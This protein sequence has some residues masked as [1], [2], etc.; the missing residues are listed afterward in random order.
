MSVLNQ[1]EQ[2]VSIHIENVVATA[3]L[4]HALNLQKIIKKIPNVQYNRKKF[5]GAIIR[6]QSPKVV[7]LFFTTGKLVCTGG[8]SADMTKKALEKFTKMLEGIVGKVTLSEVKI[9]N[10][11]S[12]ANLGRMVHLEQAA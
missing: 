6:M 3:T 5:P 10:I 4:D 8:T 11:V 1:I 7:L 12:S 9:Q 2:P